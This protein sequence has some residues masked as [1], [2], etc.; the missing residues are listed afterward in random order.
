MTTPAQIP[1]PSSTFH[2]LSQY[3]RCQL[4]DKNYCGPLAM[5]A[6]T[7]VSPEDVNAFL[8][9]EGARKLRHSTYRCV[10]MM[11]KMGIRM[12]RITDPA[13]VKLVT[14]ARRAKTY[15][16]EQHTYV[17][18]YARHIGVMSKGA[19]HDWADGQRRL[20]AVYRVLRVTPW[21]AAPRPEYIGKWES[22]QHNHTQGDAAMKFYPSKSKAIRAVRGATV[23]GPKAIEG[24]HFDLIPH[25]H[26]RGHYAYEVKALPS[27]ETKPAPEVKPAPRKPVPQQGGRGHALPR[28]ERNGVVAPRY[29]HTSAGRI[30]A[31]ANQVTNNATSM[32]ADTLARVLA[33]A[34]AEGLSATN[35]RIE[36][37]AWRKFH[38]FRGRV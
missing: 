23:L 33:L 6:I 7:G 5:C 30:W 21:E 20:Q 11:A 18:S 8:I 24:V 17:L 29:S 12:E 4:R 35:A 34:A 1:A 26:L 38:G 27:V 36:F 2:R 37:Y 25:E 16:S 22:M 28:E 10:D 13:V 32:T 9:S 3:F 14:T 31:F 19:W 15:L